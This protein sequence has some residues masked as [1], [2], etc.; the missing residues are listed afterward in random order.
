[1]SRTTPGGSEDIPWHIVRSTARA[2]NGS[3]SLELYFFNKTDAAKIWIERPFTLQPDTDY[4]Y[5]INL[6]FY[7]LGNQA[8]GNS[9]SCAARSAPPLTRDDI[10]SAVIGGTG[11]GSSP[12]HPWAQR[13]ARGR[14]R[15]DATGQ[16]FAFVGVWGT[17][18]IAYTY[19][20]DDVRIRFR[21]VHGIP[22][23]GPTS[24][25]SGGSSR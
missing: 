23:A 24:P 15:T 22:A 3:T 17:F 13:L 21:D 14:V 18:E 6:S 12:A 16:A 4:E 1:V 11:V 7:P 5:E 19:Y 10:V 2:S 9:L 20:L 25:G 8:D